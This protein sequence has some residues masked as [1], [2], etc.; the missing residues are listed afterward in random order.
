LPIVSRSAVT[1]SRSGWWRAS[2]GANILDPYRRAGAYVDKIL[3]G[4]K[5]AD[6]PVER[7]TKFDLSLI[8]PRRRAISKCA[9][10][11]LAQADEV[12]E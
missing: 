1:W 3:R 11:L 2:N 8:R 5:P 6:I 12:I 9:P 4:T 10:T 7:P